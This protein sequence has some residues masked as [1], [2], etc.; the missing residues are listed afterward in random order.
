LA[1]FG[2]FLAIALGLLGWTWLRNQPAPQRR[3]ALVKLALGLAALALGYLAVTGRLHIAGLLLAAGYPLLRRYLPA[4]LRQVQSSGSGGNQST[5][6]S[7]IIEMSLDHD[8]GV[9]HGRVLC[10]PLEG[11]TL[12]ELEEAQFIQLLRYCR[13]R[14]A[15]S[16]RLLETYLDKRFGESWRDD[17][18]AG[19]DSAGDRT[20]AE[21]GEGR[22]TAGS[23]QGELTREE[24]YEILG[25]EPGASRDE[26][27][28]A[29]RRLMQRLHPDR[30]GSAYLAARINA[31]RKLLLE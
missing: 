27:T 15:D 21:E 8:T 2:L 24:A 3:G 10:G 30:G 12:G 16:A 9:M 17:D 29:H 11:R 25:L 7:E 20:G 5:V 26:I 23:G 31:A 14:D 22:N 6:T 4:L 28:Q 19:S 18:P 1:A 13:R